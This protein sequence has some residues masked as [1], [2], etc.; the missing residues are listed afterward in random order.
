MSFFD[1]KMNLENIANAKEVLKSFEKEMA[2]L[3]LAG[4]IKGPVHFAVG[5]EE[6]SIKI[7][8]GLIKGDYAYSSSISFPDD[9]SG[10]QEK[11][12]IEIHDSADIHHP[13]F[14][15]IKNS[16]WVFGSYRNH[17]QALLHGVPA[18]W[19]KKNILKGRSMEVIHP[20]YKIFTSGIVGGQ[21]PIAV[22]YAMSL[23]RKNSSNHVWA[24]CGDMAAETGIFEEST[25]YA[26][27]FNLPITFIIE[28]NGISV[29][30]PTAQV[31]NGISPLRRSNT[32]RYFYKNQVPHQG[33]GREVGF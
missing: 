8:R 15:G 11:C 6:Q 9:I 17:L 12:Q 21:L 33:V 3:S 14:N 2:D 22:G 13:I 24:F 28:Y 4:K 5:N 29:D 31:W 25:K 26:Q 16:D 20:D 23:K 19:L 27:N 30:T 1:K 32:V 7:F 18:K 10:L